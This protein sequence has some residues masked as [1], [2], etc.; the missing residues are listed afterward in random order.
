MKNFLH[1]VLVIVLLGLSNCDALSYSK[2]EICFDY[3]IKFT[4]FREEINNIN[5]ND[6]PPR[7]AQIQLKNEDL[8]VIELD[9]KMAPSSVTEELGVFERNVKCNLIAKNT[10][11]CGEKYTYEIQISTPEIVT[12][13]G[14]DGKYD[15]NFENTNIDPELQQIPRLNIRTFNE[16]VS[17]TDFNA[18][19]S[20]A[21]YYQWEIG[22]PLFIVWFKNNVPINYM[23]VETELC[24]DEWSFHINVDKDDVK[25][26]YTV[27]CAPRQT[28]PF[29]LTPT[30]VPSWWIK[31]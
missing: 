20:E 18:D 22:Q 5:C 29:D 7:R 30:P 21:R 1:L 2:I 17:G 12:M 27:W 4:I 25:H 19:K 11:N 15:V 16:S 23:L 6:T 26:I 31:T 3:A 28:T 9:D 14:G 13:T 10:Y 24:Y 8:I